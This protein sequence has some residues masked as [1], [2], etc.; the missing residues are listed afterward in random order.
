MDEV[1]AAVSDGGQLQWIADDRDLLRSLARAFVFVRTMIFLER[2]L[3]EA[4]HTPAA[5]TTLMSMVAGES[6]RTTAGALVAEKFQPYF[7]HQDNA[8]KAAIDEALAAIRDR[9]GREVTCPD[10]TRSTR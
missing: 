6:T 7:D 4:T 1:W 8:C 9:V 2:A 3:F 5:T 10:A